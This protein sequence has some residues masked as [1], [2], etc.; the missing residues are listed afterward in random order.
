MSDQPL[1]GREQG[2]GG[3]VGRWRVDDIE[4]RKAVMKTEDIIKWGAVAIGVW[5]LYNN[6]DKLFGG[7][8]VSVAPGNVVSPTPRA[9]PPGNQQPARSEERRVGEGWRSRW[10]P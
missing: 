9:L 4:E 7:G 8:Q 3:G 1:G 2:N 5:W 6:Q 10:S